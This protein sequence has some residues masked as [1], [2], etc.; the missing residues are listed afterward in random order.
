ME[1]KIGRAPVSLGIELADVVHHLLELRLRELLQ[2]RSDAVSGGD[3]DETYDAVGAVLH[4]A[5]EACERDAGAIAEALR[6]EESGGAG[7]TPATMN[8]AGTVPPAY[9][10]RWAKEAYLLNCLN[11][12]AAALGDFPGASAA[13]DSLNS[14]VASLADTI[15]DDEAGRILRSS[16]VAEVRELIARRQRVVHRE[17]QVVVGERFGVDERGGE[18]MNHG[19]VCGGDDVVVRARKDASPVAE[20]ETRGQGHHQEARRA[21]G[22]GGARQVQAVVAPV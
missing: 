1:Q 13:R 15:A 14:R 6:P 10:A 5:V 11:A 20:D 19:G 2:A 8:A 12:M 16:G 9:T 22:A 18:E 21:Q 4:P 7:P 3:L 17:T